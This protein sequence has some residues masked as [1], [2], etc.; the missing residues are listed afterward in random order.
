MAIYNSRQSY[1]PERRLPSSL[2]VSL[3]GMHGI[4]CLMYTASE[5][6]LDI[7]GFEN[8]FRIAHRQMRTVGVVW[9]S[10]AFRG[11]DNIWE[12]CL[13]MLGKSIS[14]GLCRSCLQ[15]IQITVLFLISRQAFPH[16]VQN[17]LEIPASLHGSYPCQS[18]LHSA[19]LRSFQSVQWWRSDC[20]TFPSSAWCMDTGLRSSI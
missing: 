4:P 14:R 10:I 18:N 8:I 6:H 2:E 17:F 19:R 1:G 15:V 3:P 16:M 20:Q 12:L 9:R 5:V 11:C 13:V 7:Q